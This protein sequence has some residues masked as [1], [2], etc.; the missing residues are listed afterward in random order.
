MANTAADLVDR[1]LPSCPTDSGYCHCRVECGF[2][3]P[4][5]ATS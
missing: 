4:E 2:C 1:I 3:S 5:T